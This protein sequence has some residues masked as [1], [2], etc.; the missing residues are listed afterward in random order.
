[1]KGKDLTAGSEGPRRFQSD[2]KNLTK[3]FS[4]LGRA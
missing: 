4:L 2:K 3:T 1:M